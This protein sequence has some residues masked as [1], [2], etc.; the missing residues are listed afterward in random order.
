MLIK[1]IT[2]KH[3]LTALT[4]VDS[5]ASAF[6]KYGWRWA[7]SGSQAAV[8]VH[9][10]KN[11]V[12]K[13]F[14]A[15]SLYLEFVKLANQHSDNPHFAKFLSKVK[16]VPG[17]PNWRFVRMEKLDQLS[18]NGFEKFHK[19]FLYLLYATYKYHLQNSVGDWAREI[20]VN[21]AHRPA[22]IPLIKNNQF[23]W[24]IWNTTPLPSQ[25]WQQA[26]E[27]V[28]STAK[29]LDLKQIDFGSEVGDNFMLRNST[30]VFI[31]PYF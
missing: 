3:D 10:K 28:V 2:L 18:D 15:H 17:N 12:I 6:E 14:E 1:E 20:I 27:L 23:N 16:T 11:Y 26:C 9:P 24:D 30:L 13:V 29:K 21:L 8:G 22:S 4:D 31:D 5:V 7:G 19:E 25:S